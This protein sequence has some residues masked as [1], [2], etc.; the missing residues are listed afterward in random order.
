MGELENIYYSPLVN[1][2]F[3]IYGVHDDYYLCGG[4]T[5]YYGDAF[6]DKRR[7]Q[8]SHSHIN[9]SKKVIA[10]DELPEAAFNG[11][12]WKVRE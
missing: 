12:C 2:F 5:H 8:L 6:T 3:R 7:Q 9:Q 10:I 1:R 11:F 4:F